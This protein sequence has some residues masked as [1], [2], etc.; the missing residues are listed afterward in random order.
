MYYLCLALGGAVAPDVPQTFCPVLPCSPWTKYPSETS[1]S[2]RPPSL[3]LLTPT[4][5]L[6]HSPFYQK[7]Y[8]LFILFCRYITA[9]AQATAVNTFPP[10]ILLSDVYK[11]RR[12]RNGM[13][14]RLR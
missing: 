7:V 8:P 6:S 9:K 10:H 2:A 5:S 12:L 13:R 11:Q 14:L 4:Q 3:P 1:R